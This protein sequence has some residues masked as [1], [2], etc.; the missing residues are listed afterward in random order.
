MLKASFKKFHFNIVAFIS[1]KSKKKRVRKNFCLFSLSV[2]LKIPWKI[3]PL[4]RL[5]AG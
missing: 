3:V 2:I 4:L 5:F 1:K